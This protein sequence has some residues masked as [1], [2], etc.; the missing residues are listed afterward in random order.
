MLQ[1]HLY[2]NN[3]VKNKRIQLYI[4]QQDCRVSIKFNFKLPKTYFD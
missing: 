2:F 4:L 1:N 3:L